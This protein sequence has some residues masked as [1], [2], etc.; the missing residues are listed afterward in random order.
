VNYRVLIPALILALPLAACHRG[1]K[2][3]GA[4]RLAL[5]A[6]VGGIG[7]KGRNDMLWRACQRL[8]EEDPRVAAIDCRE[9]GNL[10]EGQ[11]LLRDVCARG[12]DAVVVASPAWEPDV[13]KLAARY[14]RTKFIVVGGAAF[15][16]NV[17]AIDF[18]VRDAGY[19]MGVAAA[20]AVPAGG[21]G[22]L[23][24][25]EDAE[26]RALAAGYAEGV[27]S[28]IPGAPVAV[29]YMGKDFAAP[30]DA[31]L[32][33]EIA[34]ELYR[35]G[36]AVIFAAAGPANA[37]IAAVAH[38][39][40]KLVIGYE[41]NQ[42]SLERGFVVTSLNIRWDD[43]VYEELVSVVE[44]RFRGRVRKINIASEFIAYPIDV[45]NRALLPADAIMKI[46]AARQRLAAAGAA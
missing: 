41:S 27:R 4:V 32:A 30:L 13:M 40:D 25:R 11:H 37:D 35:E 28:E 19:L 44:G 43:L 39:C 22:F 29:R 15:R 33:R 5:V 8:A 18:P 46:E 26:T 6:D 45:N 16:K 9:P 42:N 1:D 3:P 34:A 2:P 24:G 7:D 17:V 12:A 36:A 31:A 14:P 38:D 10:A 20:A 23:G 21:Y